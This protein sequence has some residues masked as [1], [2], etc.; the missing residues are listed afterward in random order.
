MGDVG[1][2]KEIKSLCVGSH[3]IIEWAESDLQVGIAP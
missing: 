1:S 3:H 2:L